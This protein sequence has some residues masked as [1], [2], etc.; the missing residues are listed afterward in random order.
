M[1]M[2]VGNSTDAESRDKQVLAGVQARLL[3]MAA[4]VLILAE[5]FPGR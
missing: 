5:T 4:V 3:W 2:G 1:M